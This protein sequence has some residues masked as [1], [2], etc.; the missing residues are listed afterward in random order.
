LRELT[1]TPSVPLRPATPADAAVARAW[2]PRDDDL[3]RWSGPS[4]RCPATAE[5]F[6]AD[7][8]NADATSFACD[9]AG[10]GLVGFGQVRYREQRFGHLARI[11][12]APAHRGHGLGRKLCV[13]LMH[14]AV[15]LHPIEAF[16]LYVFPDNAGAVSLY[17]SLGYV[18]QGKHPRFDCV[19]MVAPLSALADHS[20]TGR[21]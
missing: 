2:T 6:W 1:P 16:S 10:T 5:S 20:T 11:I 19:L 3:R 9:L 4:T 13:A 7:I 8:N 17:R 15:R 14:A 21:S 18:E 12:V